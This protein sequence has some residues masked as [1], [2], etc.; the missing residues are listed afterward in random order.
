MDKIEKNREI[1]ISIIEKFEEL[2]AEKNIKIPSNDR[3]GNEDEACICGR[4]YY[5]LEESITE[6]LNKER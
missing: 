6:I 1:V 3:E 5:D 4:E 2:L